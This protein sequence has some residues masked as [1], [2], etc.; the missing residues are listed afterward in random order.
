MSNVIPLKVKIY[1]NKNNRHPD[2][3]NNLAVFQK[4]GYKGGTIWYDRTCNCK[5]ETLDSP[6]GEMWALKLVD[7]E[8]ADQAV[9]AFPDRCFKMSES[10]AEDFWNNRVMAKRS[11]R[12]YNVNELQALKLEYELNKIRNNDLTS[13]EQRIDKALDE[14]DPFPGV[15]KNKIKKWEDMKNEMKITIVS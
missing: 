7:K 8:F 11:E 4:P 10:E 2:F 3:K 1:P 5:T 15:Q 12:N 6:L 9:L 13:I 14:N